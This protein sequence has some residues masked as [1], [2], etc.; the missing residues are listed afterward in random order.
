MDRR[1]T[2]EFKLDG[3]GNEEREVTEIKGLPKREEKKKKKNTYWE[4]RNGKREN[5]VNGK[6]WSR[7]RGR[8][9]EEGVI[10]DSKVQLLQRG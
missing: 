4:R 1:R 9:S 5:S 2:R 8:I 3:K 10:L 7:H 6:L